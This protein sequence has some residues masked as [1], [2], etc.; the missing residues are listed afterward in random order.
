MDERAPGSR[1]ADRRRVSAPRAVARD[2]VVRIEDGAYAHIL[3]PQM[4][5]TTSLAPRDRALVTDLVYGTVREQ[6]RLDDLLAPVGR[7]A[8]DTLD[9]PVRAALRLGAYQLVHGTPAHAAV[10]ETVAVAPVRAR[11]YV[12]AVLRA[13][14]SSG[15]PWSRSASAAV[16]LSYPDWIVERLTADLGA[17]EALAALAASNTAPTV[18]LRPRVGRTSAS[19]LLDELI[20][21]GAEAGPGSL[22]SEAVTVRRA[23][24]L[25]SLPAVAEGRATP[26]DE[27]SQ[28]V[29]AF[30]APEPGERILDV[31]AAPGGKATAIA[32]RV[33][34]HG[35]VVAA[36][37][38]PRRLSLVAT[39][40]RRLG[41]DA[42]DLI[43]ADGRALPVR[44]GAFDRALVDAPCSGLGVLRRRPDARWRISEDDVEVLAQL[45]VELVLAAAAAVRPGGL[46]VFSV[47]TLTTA[48]TLGVAE[49][50][51][52][53]LPG[54]TAVPRPGL[55]WRPHGAGALLLPHD[56]G[57]DGM[58]LLGLRRE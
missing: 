25:A 10:G 23:G 35:Q 6:R 38:Q 55:P 52:A 43:A 24:D 11:G 32:E 54:F 1:A 41:L 21:T 13:L 17:D 56:A 5:R 4:L 20:A 45:Q 29:V 8:L 12:N 34:Q 22:M 57:T 31:A 33:G 44:A 26:Q 50:V 14:A 46:L 19:A 48:E 53:A 16:E 18:A 27:A 7:R 15:P 47:C 37:L 2:A 36:D 30:L 3:V 40:A 39:A 28:S 42:V 49:Q 58:F 51:G 9:P